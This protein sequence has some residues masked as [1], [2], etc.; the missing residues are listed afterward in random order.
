[1]TGNYD[2]FIADVATGKIRQLTGGAGRNE[3]PTWAPDSRHIAFQSNRTGTNQI[4]IM[5]LDG[6]ELRMITRQGNNSS[7]SWGGYR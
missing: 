2:I 1:M 4:Y 3:A 5:L 6:T 7:P